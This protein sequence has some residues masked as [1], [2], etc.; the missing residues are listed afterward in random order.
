MHLQRAIL[1]ALADTPPV[2]ADEISVDVTNGAATLRG[3]VGSPLQQFVAVR[4]ARTVPGVRAVDDRLEVRLLDYEGREDADTKA[5]VTDALIGDAELNTA[6]VDVEV[7]AGRVTLDGVVAY[8]SQRERAERL[9]LAVGGVS[10]V[11][12][13]L[14]VLAPISADEV[15]E[16]VSDAIGGT[17]R[18]GTDH[19]KVSVRDGD[20]ILTGSVRSRQDRDAAVAAAARA[21]GVADVHD[22]LNVRG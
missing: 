9:A 8:A 4:A 19:V 5:A 6:D 15:A 1:A 20:V 16:R 12:N 3:T 14:R 11:E 7:E 22:E 17:A 13:R 18:A 21:P 2:H 10:G